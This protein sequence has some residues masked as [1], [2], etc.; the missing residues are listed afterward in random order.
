MDCP[1]GQLQEYASFDALLFK[2]RYP[3]NQQ[4]GDAVLCHKSRADCQSA[5]ESA[6]HLKAKVIIAESARSA[7]WQVFTEE[8][9]TD[10]DGSP[11]IADVLCALGQRQGG[12]R[13]S[14]R[15]TS[16]R[17]ISVAPEA[18]CVLWCSLPLAGQEKFR[19][20]T[21]VAVDRPALSSDQHP[22]FREYD[23]GGRRLKRG[24]ADSSG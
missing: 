10:P 7:G 18:I 14:T 2:R 12:L 4:A 21:L 5:P 11:W 16:S 24:A 3:E 1:Q 20:R 9:G 13:D 8:S 17:R 19:Y 23:R 22:G 15:S 6:E